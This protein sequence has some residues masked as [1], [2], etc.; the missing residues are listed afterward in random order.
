MGLA[1]APANLDE[2]IIKNQLTRDFEDFIHRVSGQSFEF[3]DP[4][5]DDKELYCVFGLGRIP[6]DKIAST[7]TQSLMLLYYWLKQMANASFVSSMNLMLSIISDSL[8]RFAKPSLLFHVKLYVITQY[9]PD[10]QRLASP[11]LQFHLARQ[12]NQAV[13][14]LHP[15]ELRFGHNI[16]KCLEVMHSKYDTIRFEGVK[17]EPDLF[18]TIQRL[19]FAN[20]DEQ[21]VCSYN[22]NIYQ[23]YK[24]LQEYDGDGDIVSLLMEKF[25]G[26]ADNPL[27]DIDA[28]AD[29]S[30]I[31]LFF[32]YDFHNRNLSLE[33]I[34]RQVREMLETF[35]NETEFGR[36]YIDYPMVESIRYTKQLPD[37]NY[38]TYSVT[39]S[40][41]SK[42]KGVSADFLRMTV[43]ISSY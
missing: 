36:L 39:R 25:A 4:K 27:K 42:F 12:Q 31:Y 34:N 8:M 9:L 24:D 35:N 10:D 3:Q 19:Y 20:R 6:F 1:T 26:Q 29:I 18:R 22:N 41:C 38:W 7:G 13:E 14:R 23:L 16:E 2:Y 30:E 32:D 21:I 17:R 43:S 40:E 37:A 33:E 11:R 15:K 5:D 28:S